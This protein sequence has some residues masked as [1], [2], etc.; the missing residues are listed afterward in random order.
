MPAAP[1]SP[2]PTVLAKLGPLPPRAV[3][4]LR[5]HLSAVPDPR[6]RR[7][8]WYPLVSV[9]LICACAVV[10]GARTIDEITATCSPPSPT[11]RQ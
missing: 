4:R 1:S 11:P 9:L 5:V 10:S 3:D 6:S 2:I 7:G 8:R